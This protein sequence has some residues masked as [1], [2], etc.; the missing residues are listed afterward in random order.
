MGSLNQ[1]AAAEETRFVGMNVPKIFLTAEWRQLA[2]LNYEIDPARL[3]PL[4]PAG[5]EIDL[6]EGRAFISVVGFLFLNTR[7]R[8][9]AFPC[10][11]NFE[12]INLRFYVRRHAA[13][14]WRHGVVFVRELVPR[15]AIAF[16][17]RKFYN[18]NYLALP[19]WH[20]I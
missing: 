8:G 6:W 18:E 20:R 5:T 12:E 2:M 3:R 16:I 15:A 19:M 14:G 10:H 7:V 17:A 11:Q 13:D 9:I 1:K 4:V